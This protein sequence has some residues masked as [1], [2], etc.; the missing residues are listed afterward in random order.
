MPLLQYNQVHYVIPTVWIR[1]RINANCVNI[2]FNDG[3][4]T[5]FY[6]NKTI[7]ED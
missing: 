6:L 4:W 3:K 2:D 5:L 1:E 7:Q